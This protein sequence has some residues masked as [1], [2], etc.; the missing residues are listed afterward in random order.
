MKE[1]KFSGVSADD[2]EEAI[3]G[4]VLTGGLGQNPARQSALAAGT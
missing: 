1:T 3:M 4:C 2:V